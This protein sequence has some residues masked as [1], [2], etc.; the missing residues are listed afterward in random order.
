MVEAHNIDMDERP[1]KELKVRLASWLGL[2][3]VNSIFFFLANGWFYITLYIPLMSSYYFMI[4]TVFLN[5]CVL[6]DLYLS[7][8]RIKEMHYRIL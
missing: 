8:V 4:K 3:L 7:D 1:S 5:V 2:I 6:H